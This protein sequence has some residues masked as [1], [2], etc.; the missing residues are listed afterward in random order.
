[1]VTIYDYALRE[2]KTGKQFV[3]L[4]L[5][6]DIELVQSQETGR[7]YATARRCSITS[8]F[9]EATAKGLIGTKLPG[10]IVRVQ[11]DEYDYTVPE[12][13]EIISLAHTY[14]YTPEEKSTAPV[15]S[16]MRE[17]EVLTA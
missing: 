14:Q 15:I 4:K 2:S 1:M 5:Q 13:G 7:F 9:D 11:C 17:K 8:T 10:S 3:S 6:G 16:L 12:S